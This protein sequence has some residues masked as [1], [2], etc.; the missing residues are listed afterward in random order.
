MPNLPT[1]AVT[2]P[3][4]DRILAVF[5]DVPTYKAWLK[6]SLIAA[7][8]AAEQQARNVA[9]AQAQTDAAAAVAADLGTAS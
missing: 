9:F 6:A 4:A 3:Q 1:L 8:T 7:V 2:Q 5:G